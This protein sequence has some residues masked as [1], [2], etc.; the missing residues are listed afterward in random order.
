[1]ALYTIRSGVNNHPEKSVL[2]FTT[3]LIRRGGVI[4][5]FNTT[6]TAGGASMAV[7][8]S[9]G[10]LYAKNTAE[11]YPVNNDG[12]VNVSVPLNSS[13][14][15]QIDAL[16]CYVDLEVVPTADGAGTGIAKFVVI[17]GT[18][19]TTPQAPTD[20]DITSTIGVNTPYE[21]IALISVASQ[22][23]AIHN[24]DITDAKRLPY[25]KTVRHVE[26]ITT[27]GTL[28][29]DASQTDTFEV[30]MTGNITLATPTG[31]NIGDWIYLTLIQDAT[32]GR[33]FTY[34]GFSVMS[35][36]MSLSSGAG[37]VS[38]FA[39]QK[40]TSGYAIYSAG[41]QYA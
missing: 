37:Q 6:E 31:M 28:T 30:T 11:A 22:S 32:G 35:A 27:S 20:S 38:N 21:L 14:N 39:I 26:Q 2:Q 10:D 13:A 25:L 7:S 16:I 15:N 40:T 5:G 41:R 3:D 33:T 34:T 19:A 36:D 29:L 1:M 23:T 8:V 17:P 4:S 12:I 24:E 9:A 18:P